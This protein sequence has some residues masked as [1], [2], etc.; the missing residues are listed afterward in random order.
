[1]EILDR[2]FEAMRTQDWDK[3]ASCLSEDVQRTGPY[4]DVVRGREAYR[5]FLSSVVPSLQGYELKV[6]RVR[7][8]DGKSALVE[9]SETLEV[10]GVRTEFPEALLFDFDDQGLILRVDIYIKQPPKRSRT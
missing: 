2:Y 4:L 1:M 7:S 8:I 5:E 6:L 10:D 9:L 3:L